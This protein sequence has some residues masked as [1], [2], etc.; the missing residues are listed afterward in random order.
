VV[1]HEG[2]LF[3]AAGHDSLLKIVKQKKNFKLEKN[4]ETKKQRKKQRKQK[5]VK[6]KMK[7]DN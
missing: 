7:K 1:V 4:K 6:G 3:D 5:L 2:A